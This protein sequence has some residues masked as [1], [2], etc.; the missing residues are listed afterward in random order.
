MNKDGFNFN[1]PAD[2]AWEL[3][4]KTGNI[5]YYMLYKNLIKK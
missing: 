2:S 4:E 1:S 5:S 3:F